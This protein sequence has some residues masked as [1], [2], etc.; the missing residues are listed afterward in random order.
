MAELEVIDAEPPAQG[1]VEYLEKQL[2]RAKSGDFSAIAMAVVYRD[3][4]TGSG[5]SQLHNTATMVGS[6]RALEAKLVREMLDE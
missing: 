5:Y 2:E 4:S 6:V 1:V 3:G